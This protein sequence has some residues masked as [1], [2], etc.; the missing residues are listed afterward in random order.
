MELIYQSTKSFEKD[1]RT[2]GA[3]DKNLV[4]KRVNELAML[5]KANRKSFYSRTYRP[6]RI[7]LLYG[8]DSSL[9]SMRINQKLRLIFAVDEDP[10]F[11]QIIFTLFRIAKHPGELKKIFSSVAESLYQ[12]QLDEL[13]QRE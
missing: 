4:I 12:S 2:L 13:V 3:S 7:K 11:D 10:L 8:Y 6:V 9:Y 1:L 5:Y